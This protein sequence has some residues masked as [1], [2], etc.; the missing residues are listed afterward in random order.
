M[1][2]P[3]LVERSNLLEVETCSGRRETPDCHPVGQRGTTKFP[4]FSFLKI[5]PSCAL[6]LAPVP[7]LTLGRGKTF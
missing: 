5:Y 2:Q 6:A 1:T 3:S 7:A 4:T